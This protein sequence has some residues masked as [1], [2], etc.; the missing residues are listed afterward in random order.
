MSTVLVTGVTILLR[1]M[2]KV[3]LVVED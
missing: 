2:G 3:S 1:L